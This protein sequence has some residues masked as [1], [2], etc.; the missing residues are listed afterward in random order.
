MMDSTLRGDNNNQNKQHLSKNTQLKLKLKGSK[1]MLLHE[2]KTPRKRLIEKSKFQ[3]LSPYN[4][5]N[6]K[7]F[8][9]A[10]PLMKWLSGFF[11]L[12]KSNTFRYVPAV[13]D[14]FTLGSAAF[15]Y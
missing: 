14:K 12:M 4:P 6:S 9:L 1:K 11:L 5:W 8:P 7:P 2:A 13:I 3:N 15:M 10:D